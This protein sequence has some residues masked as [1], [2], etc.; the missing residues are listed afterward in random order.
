MGTL[1][2]DCVKLVTFSWDTLYMCVW[3]KKSQCF[4]VS[5]ISEHTIPNKKGYKKYPDKPVLGRSQL[6]GDFGE[7]SQ[8]P[9]RKVFVGMCV[10]V[11]VC[12]SKKIWNSL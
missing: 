2:H 6:P 5:G 4:V 7:K 9:N 11:C 1:E 3:K 10:R 12:V 8:G